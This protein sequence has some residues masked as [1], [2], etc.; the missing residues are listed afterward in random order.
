MDT[1]KLN[2]TLDQIAAD[3]RLVEEL[4]SHGKITR[5][6]KEYSLNLLYPNSQ[7][8]LWIS[9]LLLTIGAVLVLSG[10][11]YFFAFN[12]AKITP[13]VK[14]SSIQFGIIGCLIGAYIYSLQRISGQVLLLSGSVLVGVF[15]AVFGQ[16]YQTGADAYQLFMMLSLFTLGWTLI[17][18]FAAQWIFWLVITNTFIVLWWQQAALPTKEMEF[19]IFTYMAILNGTALALREY[20]SVEKAYEWLESRWTRVV[21][22]IASLLIMMIPVVVW[23][24]EPSRATESIILSGV[25]GLAGHGAVYFFYRH[26]LPDMW[27]LAATVLSGCIITEFLIFKLMLG[28]RFW[29][30]DAGMYLTMGLMTLGIFTAA[31]IYLRKVSENMEVDH[32]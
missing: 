23:I 28:E 21:L 2:F 19:M 14:L 10:I 24:L 13:A 9:R 4:Y 1:E 32:V 29:R 16:I 22:T 30:A 31:I 15:M 18:N 11:I 12:W 17:S 6:A 5:E 27:S 7:W 26:K 3:R 20:C 25:I 8:G